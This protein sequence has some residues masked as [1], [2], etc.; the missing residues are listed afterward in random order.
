MNKLA[1]PQVINILS[2]DVG[3]T[4][5]GVATARSDVKLPSPHSFITASGDSLLHKIAALVES[6]D[7]KAIVIGLPRGLDGQTT[8]QTEHIQEIIDKITTMVTIPVFVQ[9]EALT[10]RKA[11]DELVARGKPYQKGDIDALA[12][13]Y[14][15][16]DFLADHPKVE[17]EI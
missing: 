5:T 4:R 9:D 11:E 3:D 6:E 13:T 16:Q 2:L 8:K 1:M 17:D 10:S 12:A 15:L 14:I 7:S